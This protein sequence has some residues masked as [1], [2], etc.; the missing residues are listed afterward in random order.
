MMSFC[1]NAYNV[2]ILQS[3]VYTFRT[4]AQEGKFSLL[5][6]LSKVFQTEKFKELF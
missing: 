5:L 2:V 6:F 1:R 4:G 3:A